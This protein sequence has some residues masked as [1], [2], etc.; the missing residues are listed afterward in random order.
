MQLVLPASRY[1]NPAQQAVFYDQLLEKVKSVPGVTSAGMTTRLHL[2]EPG[3][4]ILFFAEGMQ[5][6]GAQNPQARLRIVSPQYFETMGIPLVQGRMFN[7]RDTATGPRVMI[8]NE[9]MARRYFPGQNPLG[10]RITYTLDRLTCE[11]VGVVRD[12]KTA[13]AEAQAREEMYVPYPQRTVPRMT[14][15]VRGNSSDPLSLSQEVRRQVQA[16][17]KEQPV[18]KIRTMDQVI[19]ESLSQPRFTTT[20]LMIFAVV[21]LVLATIGIYGVMSY[22]VTERTKEFGI[23][24]AVGAQQRD[25]LK[26]VLGQGL[27]LAVIGVAIGLLAIIPLRRLLLTQIFGISATD[28]LTL[29]GVSLLLMFVALLAC[30][31]PALRATRVDPLDALRYE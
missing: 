4:T 16:V 5:D 27:I 28:P 2:D 20:L 7:E 9:S 11:V 29:V 24:M 31:I 23:L 21:A 30:Y 19:A 6:L 1:A 18:A 15:V 3:S 12:A 8:I 17:D 13:V 25:V 22:S 10:R 26:M 14:L